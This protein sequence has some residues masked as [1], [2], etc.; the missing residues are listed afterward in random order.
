MKMF[1]IRVKEL[2]KENG[3]TQKV[4]AEKLGTTNSAICDWEKGRSEPDLEMLK[5][6]AELFSVSTDYLVG[7]SDI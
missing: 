5:K 1:C 6:I 2:R 7:I 3:Y 4:M